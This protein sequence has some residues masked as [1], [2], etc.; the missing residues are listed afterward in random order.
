MAHTPPRKNWPVC[1]YVIQYV[2]VD[3]DMKYIWHSFM[4]NLCCTEYSAV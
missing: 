4:Q 3:V 2:S 1:L